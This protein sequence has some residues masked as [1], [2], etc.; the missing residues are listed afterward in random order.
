[1]IE[2]LGLGE[3]AGGHQV[4]TDG[5]S[6]RNH[7]GRWLVVFRAS[8]SLSAGIQFVEARVEFSFGNQQLAFNHVVREFDDEFSRD[9]WSYV[10]GAG[11]SCLSGKVTD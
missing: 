1:V 7:P 9:N 4:R 3:A 2:L 5:V 6:Y 10:R 8:S 11:A